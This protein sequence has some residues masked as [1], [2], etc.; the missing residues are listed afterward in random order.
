MIEKPKKKPAESQKKKKIPSLLNSEPSLPYSL[1]F[2]S[3]TFSLWYHELHHQESIE[4][5]C[6]IIILKS[7]VGEF[8]C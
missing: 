5:Q 2:L 4:I 8:T 7:I 3:L 1:G 6:L